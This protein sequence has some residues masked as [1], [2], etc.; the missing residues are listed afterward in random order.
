M[1]VD[2][3]GN[4][5]VD[6]NRG[7]MVIGKKYK[8]DVI[9]YGT[10][11]VIPF[12]TYLGQD[13]VNLNMMIFQSQYGQPVSKIIDNASLPI[14]EDTIVAYGKKKRSNKRS[15]SYKKRCRSYKKRSRSYKA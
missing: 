1:P 10:P 9:M 5:V 6:S 12:C 14:L 8:V 3:N 7:L 13:P 15:R 11:I 4:D 2:A